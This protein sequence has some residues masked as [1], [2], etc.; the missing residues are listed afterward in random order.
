MTL[1][2]AT[3]KLAMHV[4]AAGRYRYA[5]QLA[6]TAARIILRVGPWK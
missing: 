5:D 6:T 3:W 1:A 4:G 2:E